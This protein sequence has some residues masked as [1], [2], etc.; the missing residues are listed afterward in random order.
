MHTLLAPLMAETLA[1][2]PRRGEFPM[3]SGGEDLFFEIS[4]YPIRSNGAVIGATEFIRD[5]TD[6]KRAEKALR[7]SERKLLQ[8][9]KLEAVGRLAGG[10]AHDFNNLLTVI[11][12]YADLALEKIGPAG[13]VLEEL[14]EMRSSA[15]KAAALTAQM[16]AFSRRQVLQPK[17]FSLDR[18]IGDMTKMLRRVIGEDIELSVR[19]EPSSGNVRADPA[20]IEQV[21]LNI[22]LNARDAMPRGGT[23]RVETREVVRDAVQGPVEVPPGRYVLLT[24]ADTGTGMDAETLSHVFEPFFTTKEEGKGTGL[25]LSTAYGIVKQS[26]GWIYCASSLGL[27]TTF[28]IWLPQI[29]ERAEESQAENPPHVAGGTESVLLVEDEASVRRFLCSVLAAAGYRMRVASNGA[30]ALAVLL[31]EPADLVVT[32]MVMPRMGGKEL[33]TRVRQSYPG[34]KLLI[35]SGYLSDASLSSWIRDDKLRLLSKPF[36]PRELLVAVRESLD[37]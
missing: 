19:L 21:L 17:V 35:I 15:K 3:R 28:T 24:V 1:G 29:R 25:G 22:V 30:E 27:G 7:E 34:T 20:Q 6:R 32:D 36:G 5:I 14:R 33:A 11:T 26:G 12:G 4:L 23:V 8:S 16:L 31:E 37:G 18:L 10:I 9:H 13:V 2:N